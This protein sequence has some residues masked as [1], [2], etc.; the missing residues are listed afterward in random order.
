MNKYNAQ[1]KTVNGIKF[2]SKKEADRYCELKLLEQM[3][4]IIDLTL[5]PRFRILDGFDYDG[6]HYRP[7]NYTADFSYYDV[8]K[9]VLIV[10]EV[11]GHKTRD[12]VI[13]WKIMLNRFKDDD[14][15]LFKLI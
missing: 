6:E 2:S 9:S 4:M 11:K 3:G 10:E 1:S 5:Q 12:F 15:I 14:T 7:I 8:E 13:R